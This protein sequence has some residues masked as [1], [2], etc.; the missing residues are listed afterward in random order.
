[1]R[2]QDQL[3]GCRTVRNAGPFGNVEAA[4]GG[5]GTLRV[6]GWAIDPDTTGPINVHV[7]V[8][9]VGRANVVARAMVTWM[10]SVASIGGTGFPEVALI[11]PLCAGLY[12]FRPVFGQFSEVETIAI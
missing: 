6:V 12:W 7:Y 9:G 10:A 4:V 5:S 8:D 2:G 1:M 11:S 3:L